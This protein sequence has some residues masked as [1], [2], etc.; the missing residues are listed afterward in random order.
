MSKLI[1]RKVKLVK[2][3]RDLAGVHPLARD[4]HVVGTVLTLYA[5]NYEG[6]WC[7]RCKSARNTFDNYCLEQVR[8]LN[9]KKVEL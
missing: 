6:R 9:N 7:L 3:V 2:D 4:V 5:V 8:Y 1:G